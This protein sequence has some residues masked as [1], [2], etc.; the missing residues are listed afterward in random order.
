MQFTDLDPA[1]CRNG[2]CAMTAWYD[3]ALSPCVEVAVE[4]KVAARQDWSGIGVKVGVF[5]LAVVPLDAVEAVVYLKVVPLGMEEFRGHLGTLEQ[6][7]Y[8][9]GLAAI[10][11]PEVGRIQLMPKELAAAKEGFGLL[12][13]LWVESTEGE[14]QMPSQEA[15]KK[16]MF[17]LL[18]SVRAPKKATL[19]KKDKGKLPG[20]DAPA[21]LWPRYQEPA[22]E[23]GQLLDTLAHPWLEMK[24][25]HKLSQCHVRTPWRW[26]LRDAEQKLIKK[27]RPR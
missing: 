1:M 12:P 25:C 26:K 8:I 3:M 16:E 22:N 23:N 4:A 17:G 24:G 6:D 15:L 7:E 10:R 5:R 21:L 2:E 27:R 13:F 14:V 9:S 20:T 18:R 11:F 19:S